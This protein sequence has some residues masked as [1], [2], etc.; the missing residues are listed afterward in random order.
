MK[1]QNSIIKDIAQ[2]SYKEI[3]QTVTANLQPIGSGAPL[4]S[5]GYFAVDK[6]ASVPENAIAELAE[7]NGWGFLVK[8]AGTGY[9]FITIGATSGSRTLKIK[10]R[11][12]IGGGTA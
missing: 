2:R 12:P 8:M 7:T 10:W 6:P 5:F 3:E 11:Y 4:S 9:R 1:R